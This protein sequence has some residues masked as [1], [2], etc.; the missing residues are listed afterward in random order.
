MKSWS[1]DSN[2]QHSAL[3]HPPDLW[4]STQEMASYQA[5]PFLKLV[6]HSQSESH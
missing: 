3:D 5:L 1:G 4:N 6:Q 2:S